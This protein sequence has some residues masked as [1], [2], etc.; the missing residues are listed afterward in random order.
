MTTTI[1]R[2]GSER[3]AAAFARARDERRL[4]LIAYLVTGFPD[5]A[6]TLPL[7]RAAL[8]S[9]ADVL[10]LGVPFSDPLADGTTIQ[11][12]SE[13]AL[14]NGVR[15]AD[16]LDV[17]RALTREGDV[18]AL[19]MGYANPFE[20]YGLERLA[21]DARDA[22][23]AG[24]IV[25][26][27]PAEEAGPLEAICERFRLIRISLFAPTTPDDRLARL[28]P[29]CRG[30]VYCVSLTG[31]T[32]ARATLAEDVAPFVARVRAHARVPVAV[33]FGISRPEHVAALRGV[34]DGVVVGSALVDAIA[35]ASEPVGA[36]A[37]LIAS[38]RQACA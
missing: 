11:R 23:V 10:E 16:A 35:S 12:A 29:G 9:G 17:A 18:A 19:L 1:A 36:L 28:V 22:G 3:I 30:F 31:V 21:A 27:L 7:A 4:A 24:L 20:Q 38:L 26:D 8:G 13:R 37:A 6:A 25:P 34:A 32:G 33:G 2:A 14:A 5:L 15:V